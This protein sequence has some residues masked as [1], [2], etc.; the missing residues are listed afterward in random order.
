MGIEE[1]GVR[2]SNPV[3]ENEQENKACFAQT[4]S[5]GAALNRVADAN[6]R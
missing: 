2:L 4:M 3:S 5:L 6:D 1:M